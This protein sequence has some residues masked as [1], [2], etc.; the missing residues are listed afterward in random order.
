VFG[1]KITLPPRNAVA[2]YQNK[3]KFNEEIE[4]KEIMLSLQ[5]T[6]KTGHISKHTTKNLQNN[7]LSV[8]AKRVDKY[9]CR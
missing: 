7:H 5:T 8:G 1:L 9:N 6:L 2:M 4:Q 3:H